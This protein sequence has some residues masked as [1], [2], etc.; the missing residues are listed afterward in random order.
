MLYQINVEMKRGLGDP[1]SEG[2]KADILDLG[3]KKVKDVHFT[4]I[5][6]IDTDIKRE[7]IDLISKRF[8]ADP[9]TH[10]YEIQDKQSAIRNPQSAMSHIITVLHKPGVMDPVEASAFKS[11]EDLG[12]KA[13]AVQTGRQFILTGK[14][15]S[16]EKHQIARKILANE[17]IDNIFYGPVT[18]DKIILGNPYKFE[19]KTIPVRQLTLVEFDRINKEQQLSLNS[20]ELTTIQSYFN[21][22][23]RDPTDIELETIAQTW[24]EHCKHKT[25]R[26]LI[27]YEET[28]VTGEKRK[29]QIDNLL[30]QTVMKVTEE[31]AKSWCIS[32]FKDN[33]G[34]IDF[35]DTN[36]VCFKVETHNHPSAI[37]PYGGAGTGLGG[38]IRDTL[39]CGLGAKPIVN[40]DVFA[41]G[42]PDLPQRQLPQGVL[43]PKRIMKGVVAGVRD[44]G[45]RMGIPTPNGSVYFDKRYTGNPLVYCG[46]VGI[47]PKN[48]C[49]KNLK[50]GDL[51]LLVGGR[52]GR[53]GIHGVTFAS[54]ELTEK[55]ES[56]S[57]IAVQIGNA[58]ME[59]KV[60]DT[61]L[62]ARDLELYSSITDCGGGGLSS[63]IG[64]MGEETGAEV[65]LEKV[66]LKYDGLSYAEIWISEA[67]E[68]MIL[69][70]PLENKDK[71]MEIFNRE[72]VEATF[73][74]RFT[75]DKKLTLRYKDN[76]VAN[77]DMEFLHHGV[78][79]FF[80]KAEWRLPKHSEPR[81][82]RLNSVRRNYG[83]ILRQLLGMWNIAS[84]EWIIR[85][86]DH[87]V[88]GGST[89]K[90][91]V[92]IKNDGPSDACVV[93][94]LLN[95][96]RG[97][98]LANGMNPKYS[99]IDP[100]HM[101]ASVID[102]ALRNI[103]AVGGNPHRTAI[104]DNFS[105]GN[106][107]KPD[108]LG[109][110]VRA[111]RACY[112]IAKVYGTP[113]IS[114]KDSL[115]NEFRTKTNSIA[116]PHTL[117]I[118]A[119]SVI[120]DVRKTITMDLKSP[121]DLI[122]LVGITNPELGGSHYY[123]L[124]GHIGNSVPQVDPQSG[125]K[126][127]SA[128][129]T[130][131]QRGCVRACHDLS[132]G[133]LGVALA[134]MAFAGEIGVKIDLEN[135][136]CGREIERDDILLFSESNSRFLVEVAPEHQKEFEDLLKDCPIGL[137]GETHSL[138]M[139]RITGLD[140][141]LIVNESLS[142]L[143]ESWQKPLRF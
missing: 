2:V 3:I 12:F 107:N 52:T 56:I 94:P 112:D 119:I 7:E 80:R 129:F 131:I 69:A 1:V 9:V 78:P 74:G 88:Q 32:V 42:P 136:F 139:L 142:A 68:R 84:K 50:P 36:A 22:I 97:L 115:N 4:Q 37:E 55:S 114:G 40:T 20:Q 99:D 29:E 140:S 72:N 58:I 10:Q 86:Y 66:P 122:Y 54:A 57:S 128:L 34:I 23:S 38:V 16:N 61:I 63:A 118:S 31:L 120:D 106:T 101:A 26:G 43:H 104:L 96:Y 24:S 73:I 35:D 30:K 13:K 133:G 14:L 71:I 127:M 65:D 117:L 98:V 46:N 100:Y 137:I 138:K 27:E 53:D 89:V 135:I 47:M 141:K 110:L 33:A 108:R 132:E 75:G 81:M 18:I 77:L 17:V 39:G 102:E 85:Q 103:V 28:Q 41:F 113:F 59:K 45:N 60:T 123:E 79:K 87:E 19:L 121:G 64:E 93:R 91:L 130:A 116:I 44:Y 62:Q 15:N 125:R 11:I 92:G 95:S 109:A 83:K 126:I 67:Q 5:Y 8:L 82:S 21:S 76:Q 6:F 70:V 25:L 48:K 111:S 143:K 124:L 51:I 134:E 90:P 105:W 49:V